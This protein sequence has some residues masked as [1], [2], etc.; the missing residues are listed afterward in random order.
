[1]CMTKK[2]ERER[3]PSDSTQIISERLLAIPAVNQT[4]QNEKNSIFRT[5]DNDV[6]FS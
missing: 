6:P 2:V 5:L 4:I 3:E 1:M